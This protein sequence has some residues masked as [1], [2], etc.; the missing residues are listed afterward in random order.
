M[1]RPTDLFTFSKMTKHIIKIEGGW[2]RGKWQRILINEEV[3][4]LQDLLVVK[5]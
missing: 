2:P 1:G 5:T 3:G 4:H